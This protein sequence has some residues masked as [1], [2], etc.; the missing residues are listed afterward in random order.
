MAFASTFD[1][2]AALNGEI[3]AVRI[4]NIDSGSVTLRGGASKASLHRTVEYRG[5]K[6]TRQTHRVENGIL[7][8]RDCGNNCSVRYTID[9]PGR[10]PVDGATDSGSI[11]LSKVGAVNVSTD[12][13]SIH[14]DDVAGSV[15]A[16]TDNGKIEG[17][18]LKG[19]GI[20]ARTDNGKITLTL[21]KPQNIRA[22]TSNGGVTVTVPAGR[23]RVSARTD[24]GDRTI[25]IPDDASAPHRLDL[26]TDNG[27][28]NVRPAA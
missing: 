6:P 4:D 18:G 12:S 11:K 28:I 17:R 24:N 2:D 8:L 1:D 26:T 16:K 3:K 25:G 10:V 21:G 20:D 13:G 7:K 5:D 15:N 9:L 23:Y 14:L 27:D 19:D 22:V